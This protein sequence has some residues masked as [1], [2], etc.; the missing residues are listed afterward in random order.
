MHD[1]GTF[2]LLD[3]DVNI[4]K[5][6]DNGCYYRTWYIITNANRQTKEIIMTKSIKTHRLIFDVTSSL[7]L[8]LS[9][10]MIIIAASWL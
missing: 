8:V 1:I 7:Y 5:H 6:N 9:V 3:L 4:T 2:N 10:C